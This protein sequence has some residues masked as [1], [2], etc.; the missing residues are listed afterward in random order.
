MSVPLAYNVSR[1]ASTRNDA[2]ELREEKK[3]VVSAASGEHVCAP[4]TLAR[5]EMRQV[6]RH[7][8]W[9]SEERGALVGMEEAREDWLAHHAQA[10]RQHRHREALALQMEE[11]RKHKWIESEKAHRDL[12]NEAVVDWIK[13]HAARW[14]KWFEREHESGAE[15]L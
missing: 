3:M 12:G 6:R 10:W 14:R 11:I 5:A 7:Q 13:N 9:L 2:G 4:E 15:N 1:S 8:A